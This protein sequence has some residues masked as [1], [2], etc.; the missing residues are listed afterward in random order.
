MSKPYDEA[1]NAAMWA[2]LPPWPAW[3]VVAVEVVGEFRVRVT[4]E[5]GT[6]GEHTFAPEDFRGDFASIADPE[7]FATATIVDGDTLGWVLPGGVIYDVAPDALW[8]H[9]HGHCDHSCGHPPR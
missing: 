9:A 1:Q 4:H 8:L 5:D 6:V 7:V 2:Q 3:K